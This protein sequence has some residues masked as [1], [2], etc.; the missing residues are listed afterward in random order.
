MI[1]YLHYPALESF[2]HSDLISPNHSLTFSSALSFTSGVQFAIMLFV[3]A[4]RAAISSVKPI[5][6]V[7]SGSRSRGSIKYPSAPNMV[8][9]SLFET[10]LS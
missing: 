7:M 2:N 3:H 10:L 8:A 6:G 5:I 4:T 9:L 1:Q